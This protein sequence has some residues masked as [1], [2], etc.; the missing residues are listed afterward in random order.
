MKRVILL[1]IISF[2]AL[3]LGAGNSEVFPN[4]AS[5]QFTINSDSKIN[6][7]EVY[8]FLGTKVLE[9]SLLV[10]ILLNST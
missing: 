10:D 2:Q 9:A 6:F 4:P 5:D 1:I 8:N 3:F 7:I